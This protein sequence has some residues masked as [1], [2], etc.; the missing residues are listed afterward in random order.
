[1][2]TDMENGRPVQDDRSENTTIA[3]TTRPDESTA[4]LR[5]NAVIAH[6]VCCDEFAALMFSDY[7]VAAAR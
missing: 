3:D 6:R 7:L 4:D 2:T 1:M 5:Q